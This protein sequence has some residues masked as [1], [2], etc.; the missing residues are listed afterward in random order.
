V[1]A[2]SLLGF[3]NH[4]IADEPPPTVA[5]RTISADEFLASPFAQFFRNDD[6]ERAL[7]AS[8]ILLQRY[9]NDPLVLRYRAM[10][11]DRLGR[12]QEAL[13][14]Y[15]QILRQYPRHAPTHFYMGQAYER[16]G[17][18]ELAAKE[19]KAVANDTMAP[20]EY[21]KWAKKSLARVQALRVVPERK[22]WILFGNIGWDY[23]TNV[24][25]K[26]EDKALAVAGD[27]NAN[28]FSADVMLRYRWLMEPDNQVDLQ[29]TAR[30]SLHDDSFDDL[31]FTSQEFGIDNRRRTSWGGRDVIVTGRYA[32]LWGF[33]ES[34]L[35]SYGN[36]FTAQAETRFTQFTRT[37]LSD[38]LTFFNFGPDGFNPDL[39]SRDG[40]YND[41][42]LSH[43][44]YTED[45]AKYLFLRQELNLAFTRGD[46]FDRH[47]ATS[48]IG[49]HTPLIADTD[50]DASVGLVYNRYPDFSSLSFLDPAERRDS[51]WDTAVSLTHRINA[52]LAVRGQYRWIHALNRNDFFQYNRHILGV[53]LLFTQ[54]F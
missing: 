21:R 15:K 53:H 16:L 5:E 33:L 29:Y 18:H 40:I 34:D 23:D 13:I 24:P 19:W 10:T 1:L 27:K 12:T 20:S 30:Q 41:L 2:L 17:D 31:N 49:V 28:R 35:F 4:A 38:Q 54:V 51:N 3:I 50:L 11:L 22:R 39:S 43:Y 37:I 44:F 47:G 48:R 9:P 14:I 6:Y 46:N 26:P 45:L 52:R 25:L 42:A 32:M 8:E 7:E 36:R